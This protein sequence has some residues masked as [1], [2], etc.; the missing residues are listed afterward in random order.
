MKKNLRLNRFLFPALFLLFYQVNSCLAEGLRIIDEGVKPHPVYKKVFLREFSIITGNVNYKIPVAFTRKENTMFV[1]SI[2]LL[3]SVTGR[4]YSKRG[5]YAGGFI[6]PFIDNQSVFLSPAVINVLSDGVQ[7]L[8]S[9][10]I[11]TASIKLTS[12]K[13]AN[14]LFVTIILPE[15][16]TSARTT[17]SCYPGD[18]KAKYPLQRD[19]WIATNER[20]LQHTAGKETRIT[21]EEKEPWVYYYDKL[22]N[23]KGKPWLSNCALLYNPREQKQV[24]VLIH[25]Y[26]MKTTLY[27]KE[28]AFSIHLVLWEFP[29]KD[30][31]NSLKYMKDLK[32]YF[33]E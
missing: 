15:K 1:Q 19:K 7:I 30:H 5:W 24:D 17:L 32:I 16:R 12:E 29:G 18:F 9:T 28:T 3:A 14:N 23:P 13:Q 4:K 21:L 10:S 25:P 26:Y 8:F 31:F 6:Y 33:D 20:E 2:G 11:G 27:H 22:N